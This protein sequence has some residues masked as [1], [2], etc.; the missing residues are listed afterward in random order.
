MN[1]YVIYKSSRTDRLECVTFSGDEIV[2]RAFMNRVPSA[3]AHI[4]T[5][6]IRLVS[7]FD[8]EQTLIPG[9]TKRVIMYDGY[10]DV[11]GEMLWNDDETYTLKFPDETVRIIRL[12]KRTFAFFHDD[13]CVVTLSGAKNQ[14][15][16]SDGE[17]D[18]TPV[19]KAEA[20]ENIS[21]RTLYTALSFLVLYFGF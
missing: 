1:T 11:F 21:Q 9:V 10:K 3:P 15:R 17:Y 12:D 4:E 8:V 19:Y 6:G 13:V 18:Y 20:A 14:P 5:A 7:E 16:R 2:L